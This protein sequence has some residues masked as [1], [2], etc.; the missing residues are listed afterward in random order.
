MDPLHW[1]ARYAHLEIVELLLDRSASINVQQKDKDTPLHL[2]IR[3]DQTMEVVRLLVK[4]SADQNIRNKK[5]RT[6]LHMA[7][8][9]DRKS[10]VNILINAENLNSQDSNG[11][12][13]LH[14]AVEKGVVEV[15]KA[16]IHHTANV[17][18]QQAKDKWTPL[19]L[20]ARHGRSEIAKLLIDASADA[21][22]ARHKDNSTAL[23]LAACN[24]HV[25][26]VRLLIDHSADDKENFYSLLNVVVDKTPRDDIKIYTGDFNAKIGSDNSD[27]KRIMGRHGLGEMSANGE[28]LAEFCGNNDMV[29]EGQWFQESLYLV[30]IDYEKAFDR[31]NHENLWGALR[32]KGVP[33]KIV[34]L[35][36]A[37]YEA[38]SCRVLHNGALSDPIRVIA[39]V[40]QRC[41]LPPL[42]FLIVIDEIMV[43]AVGY[44]VG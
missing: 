4:R 40:R 42:L 28:L 19:H 22:E 7:A 43:G 9:F 25:D 12:T 26:T 8:H 11:C 5:L 29:I 38:L 1:A 23:H 3:Y 37:Q 32:R 10:I 14:L 6:P 24:G 31:L 13:P 27:Y 35:I 21:I 36:E 41:I 15:V 34:N 20:A 33:D 16:L 30:F 17:L 44:P 2:A 18:I 39:D